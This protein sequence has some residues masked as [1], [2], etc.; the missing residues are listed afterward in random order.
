MSLGFQLLHF[1]QTGARFAQL[2]WS[3]A[4][5]H[6][7]PDSLLD[8]L[9]TGR[10]GRQEVF[11][12]SS[13]T[14]RGW[15]RE[16]DQRGV[17]NACPMMRNGGKHIVRR[18]QIDL[19]YHNFRLAQPN[20]EE[21]DAVAIFRA[22]FERAFADT[23]SRRNPQLKR[24]RSCPTELQLY[25]SDGARQKS[26]AGGQHK[27]TVCREGC[28]CKMLLGHGCE[29]CIL[30]SPADVSRCIRRV[31]RLRFV[32]I[33]G[34]WE[35]SVNLFCKQ[36]PCSSGA[37]SAALSKEPARQE[38]PACEAPE[39]WV[40]PADDAVYE[41]ALL[42]MQNET[43]RLAMRAANLSLVLAEWRA[44]GGR[45]SGGGAPLVDSMREAKPEVS[46]QRQRHRFNFD[47]LSQQA[48][49]ELQPQPA[50]AALLSAEEPSL[51]QSEPDSAPKLK[52][53]SRKRSHRTGPGS[54]WKLD[55]PQD[56]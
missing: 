32:G 49:P 56:G 3:V 47:V 52:S 26:S 50:L 43:R 27:G 22:P 24:K 28:Q 14:Y 33:T 36:F 41:A 7:P 54:R 2:V 38:L 30:L 12:S 4:C 42:R 6:K 16:L 46:S 8:Y 9:G 23:L 10:L 45:V 17:H 19:Q 13:E 21:T 20:K 15:L 40:D 53:K 51:P 37:R 48:P 11:S 35:D 18:E 25:G 5:V 44:V 1:P 31:Q 55:S 39:L 29:D 34:A